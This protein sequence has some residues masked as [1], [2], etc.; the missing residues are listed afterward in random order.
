MPKTV[1]SNGK[2]PLN[3][4]ILSKPRFLMMTAF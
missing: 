1:T 4:V 3:T 2:F